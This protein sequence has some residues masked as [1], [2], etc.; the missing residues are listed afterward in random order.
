MGRDGNGW[1]DRLHW[2]IYGVCIMDWCW[3]KSGW[4]P[5]MNIMITICI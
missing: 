2:C 5:V 3:M 1:E 4:V